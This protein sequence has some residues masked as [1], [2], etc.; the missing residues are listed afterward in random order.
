MLQ[1]FEVLAGSHFPAVVDGQVVHR[2]PI[3][4]AISSPRKPCTIVVQQ[5]EIMQSVC[6]IVHSGEGYLQ[7]A[8]GA[9]HALWGLCLEAVCKF[10]PNTV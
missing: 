5:N 10:A 3:I 6:C 7:N 8:L 9:L 4:N 1:P 2:A